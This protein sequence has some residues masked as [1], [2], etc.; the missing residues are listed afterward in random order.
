MEKV[1]ND[2]KVERESETIIPCQGVENQQLPQSV[3][4]SLTLQH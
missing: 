4:E 2:Q 3:P 1:K